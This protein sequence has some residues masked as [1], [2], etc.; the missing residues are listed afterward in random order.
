MKPYIYQ[1]RGK[2][3]LF[4]KVNKRNL[5]IILMNEALG[6]IQMKKRQGCSA[7]KS[8]Q[9]SNCYPQKGSPTR[10][11][12]GSLNFECSHCCHTKKGGLLCPDCLCK[13]CGYQI[14]NSC[15]C[16]AKGAYVTSPL[17]KPWALSNEFPWQRT[18]LQSG[19]NLLLK[20]HCKS[21]MTPQGGDSW[22]TTGRGLCFPL[23]FGPLYFSLDSLKKQE[24]PRKT[25]ISALL[26]T[27]KSLTVWITISC[28]KF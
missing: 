1:T 11:T 8:Y 20:E 21:C 14:S 2:L 3:R 22:N 9:A 26:T 16:R 10:L 7:E 5:V 18:F 6:I 13:Q 23:D 25:S 12:S 4:K 24:S 15:I 19:S 17:Q 28:G 27:P